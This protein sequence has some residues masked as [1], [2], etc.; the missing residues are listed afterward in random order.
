MHKCFLL[1]P[2]LSFREERKIKS[3]MHITAKMF[4]CE[5]CEIFQN[6]LFKEQLPATHSIT[7]YSIHINAQF[8]RKIRYLKSSLQ[9]KPA[10]ILVKILG[11]V[12]FTFIQNFFGPFQRIIKWSPSKQVQNTEPLKI[13]RQY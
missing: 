1:Q 11:N 8:L 2:Q 9:R 13:C 7:A 3:L 10:K 6:I 5:F 4:S 12:I